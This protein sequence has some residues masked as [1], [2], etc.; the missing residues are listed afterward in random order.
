MNLGLLLAQRFRYLSRRATKIGSAKQIR[1]LGCGATPML[2]LFEFRLLNQWP[3]SGILEMVKVVTSASGS[4]SVPVRARAKFV[5]QRLPLLRT[6]L[7]GKSRPLAAPSG[8][9]PWNEPR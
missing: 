1:A 7:A 2:R 6:M 5:T 3:P 9:M 4:E 8:P